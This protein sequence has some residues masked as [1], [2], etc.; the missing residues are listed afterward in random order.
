MNSSY[1]TCG[2]VIKRINFGEA[3]RILTIFTERFGKVK[4]IARGVRKTKSKLAGHLEPF[5]LVDLQLYEGKTFYTVTGAMIIN[6]FPALHLDLKKISRA[7]YFGE[8]IDKFIEENQKSATIFELF[9]EVLRSLEKSND[10]FIVRIFELKLIESAGF[11]PQLFECVHCR[12]KLK[13][14]ENFWDEVEGGVIC[15][16]CQRKFKH[17]R[18]ISDNSIKILRLIEKND[19]GLS[20]RVKVGEKLKHELS[21][22][23][24]K[25]IKNI[26]EKEL[27]TESFMK[28]FS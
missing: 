24:S 1:K 20:E 6:E 3:D 28:E 16:D 2:V 27:K 11:K 22:I 8:L 12:E 10:E 13:A 7:F 21:E 25:Y 26:L 4:A 5:M 9:S 14:G 15:S 23:L 19:F 18:S 17:G